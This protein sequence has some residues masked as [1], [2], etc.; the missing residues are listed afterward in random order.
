MRKLPFALL[1]A[2]LLASCSF[3]FGIDTSSSTPAPAP[4]SSSSSEPASSSSAEPSSEPA[5]SS[6]ESETSSE[7][8]AEPSSE[9]S[10]EPSSEVSSS[11]ASSTQSSIEEET[12]E[13]TIISQTYSDYGANQVFE[14]D[15]SPSIGETHLLVI[16]V[17]FTDSSTFITSDAK[18]QNV[19]DDIEKA[20]FGTK[21][22]AGWHSVKTYYEEESKGMLTV[23]GVVSDWYSVNKSYTVYGSQQESV[24]ALVES[25][26]EWY[27]SLP[28]AKS[29]SYF[30]C[31]GNG[32]LDG[33]MLI[34][35]APD[36]G[37]L[38]NESYSNLWA[39]CYWLQDYG[40]KNPANP[41][42]NVYFWASYAFLYSGWRAN[43]RAGSWYGSGDNSHSFLDTHTFIHEMGHV[44]GLDDYYDYYDQENTPAGGFS[45]QDYN[46]G[47]HDPYSVMALGWADPYIPYDDCTI[48]L[49]PFQNSHELILLTP[50]WNEHDSPFDEYLLLE[51]YTPTGLH[52]LD[53]DY[54]YSG[55]YPK[56]PSEVGIRLWHI[57]A[58]LT[59][60]ESVDA[61]G[62]PIFS[63]S[64]TTNAQES[65]LYGVYHAF[66]NNSGGDRLTPMGNK[67]VSHDLLHLIRNNEE[68]G[69][70]TKKFFSNDDLFRDGDVFSLSTHKSQFPNGQRLRMNSGEPFGWSFNVSIEGKGDS[71]VA[72]VDCYIE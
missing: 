69:L 7:A 38:Q 10:I 45:M 36:Y 13:K 42:P 1:P 23:D 17:W 4:S 43:E 30:D 2:L 28:S 6:I 18:K 52:K 70:K 64:F 33:V 22:D 44:F 46:V 50:Q 3:S 35:G 9:P 24:D 49:H 60:C 65:S 58:R 41:G 26:T 56:G 19:R 47:G 63:E 27:F 40:L 62:E 57:D 66:N 12:L 68:M 14:V 55:Y 5:S 59:T 72:N 29:R 39:Y 34:Y 32:Y 11:E 25:A 48:T 53:C 31:D 71:L 51:F 20:Y 54:S 16:P 67:F 21:E 15:Y 37:A 8:S 61:R